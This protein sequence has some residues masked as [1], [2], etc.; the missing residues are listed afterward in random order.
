MRPVEI[1][2]WNK[3]LETGMHIIDEQH[4]KL[5]KLVNSL[6]EHLFVHSSKLTINIILDELADYAFFHFKTEEEVWHKFL[7]NDP[8]E[9][10][11]KDTHLG[12]VSD[13][14]MLKKKEPSRQSMEEILRFLIQWLVFHIL[15]NDM[16]MAKVVQAIQSGLSAQGAKEKADSEM[17][18]HISIL[19]ETILSTYE[20]LS[21]ISLSLNH[22]RI[23]RKET[24]TKL[25]LASNVVEHTLDAICVTDGNKIIIDAN[26]AF[27]DTT[28]YSH[29]DVIGR[30]IGEIKSG[31][32]EE[33]VLSK[34]N[35]SLLVDGYWNGMIS[36]HNKE[37]EAMVEWLSLSSVKGENGDD[38]FVA[39]F[40]EITHLADR[41]SDIEHL[42]YHDAL[43]ELPNR[44][45]LGDRLELALANANR[46]NEYLAVCYLDL[47]GFKPVNDEFGHD[48]GDE[49]L[50]IT[51]Q[52]L[53]SVLRTND[54]V[55]RVGGDEFVLLLG[56]FKQPD[57]YQDLLERV[58]SKINQPIQLDN[59]NEVSVT[60]SI[61]VTIYPV[62]N[63]KVDDLIQHADRAMY[64][65]K[66]SGTSLYKLYS[67]SNTK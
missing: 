7:P 55:S 44:I 28:R 33:P 30:K 18:H 27:Y 34:V 16:Y 35:K 48:A 61:G 67:P 50:K 1:F 45:L 26:P 56:D 60:A 5:V 20:Q 23:V 3:N 2:P 59:H 8:L 12:F 40:S 24:E 21:S 41:L 42:A 63:S 17:R 4:K 11:H 64:Q 65:A 54:T 58:L 31:L 43:T 29:D 10:E 9:E 15:E 36:S 52:R 39:V 38:H 51:A 46:K 19:I 47:D 66:Q 25:R 32:Y 6:A 49:V 13:I 57:D 37:G 22:E 53:L 62:D 14:Q